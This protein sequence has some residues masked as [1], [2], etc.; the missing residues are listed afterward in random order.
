MYDD[1]ADC[2]S[3]NNIN[4]HVLLNGHNRLRLLNMNVL[5]FRTIL[6]K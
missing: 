3:K 4:K 6:H 2:W 5:L 1:N